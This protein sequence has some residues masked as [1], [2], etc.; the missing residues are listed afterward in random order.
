MATEKREQNQANNVGRRHLKWKL[1]NTPTTILLSANQTSIQFTN[2]S[3]IWVMIARA[4]SQEKTQFCRA[5]IQCLNPSTHVALVCLLVFFSFLFFSFLFFFVVDCL[6][7]WLF[8]CLIGCYYCS[9]IVVDLLI[10]CWNWEQ[11][12]NQLWLNCSPSKNCTLQGQP[13]E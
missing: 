13:Q 6:I 7:V 11:F 10:H 9:F 8:N 1:T 5:S 4:W 3:S 2:S 12:K